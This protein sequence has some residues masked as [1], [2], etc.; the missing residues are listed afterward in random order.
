MMELVLI[1]FPVP[2]PLFL[3]VQ[4][5]VVMLDERGLNVGSE[6]IASL[7]GDAGSTV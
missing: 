1:C 3:T 4:V 5:Q 2:S 7:I 6:Q